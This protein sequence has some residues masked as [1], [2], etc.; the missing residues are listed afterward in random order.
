V[1]QS[2]GCRS[3]VG[4]LTARAEAQVLR[5][6]LT[7]AIVDCSAEI[8]RVH[9]E[10]ARELWRF[11]DDSARYIFGRRSGNPTADA[12]LAELRRREQPMDRTD[13]SELFKRHATSLQIEA[14]LHLLELLG[15]IERGTEQTA[16]RPR[17]L[18]RAL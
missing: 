7:Y 12:I 13:I 8:R 17:E 18:W 11:C 5:L 9:L 6:A 4:A 2:Q 1:D 15:R 3:L 14:A 16:G 10:A